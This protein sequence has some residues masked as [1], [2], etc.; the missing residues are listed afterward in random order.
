MQ[1]LAPDRSQRNTTSNLSA[2]SLSEILISSHTSTIVYRSFFFLAPAAY[3]HEKKEYQR[4]T[5][6]SCSSLEIIIQITRSMSE[7]D[8]GRNLIVASG[9]R[10]RLF[11][12][13]EKAWEW[14]STQYGG[15]REPRRIGEKDWLSIASRSDGSLWWKN[16]GNI[17]EDPLLIYI[18]FYMPFNKLSA[19]VV[20]QN[21]TVHHLKKAI[22]RHISLKLFREGGLHIVSW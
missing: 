13:L 8:V 20:I 21:A 17:V 10:R 2:R 16:L 5:I 15:R 12:H 18:Y 4:T 14:T 22:Q 3:P 19:V 11:F 6:L 9:G 1:K 7:I